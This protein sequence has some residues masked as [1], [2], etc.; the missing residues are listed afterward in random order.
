MI[1]LR[2]F[3]ASLYPIFKIAKSTT[4]GFEIVNAGRVFDVT[5]IPTQKT[6]KLNRVRRAKKSGLD[7]GLIAISYCSICSELAVAGVCLNQRCVNSRIK[8]KNV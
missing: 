4:V 6:P 2:S 7:S 3:Q 1:A 5:I 8:Q